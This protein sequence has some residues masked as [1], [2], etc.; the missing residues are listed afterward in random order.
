MMCA[1]LLAIWFPAFEFDY[2]TKGK[3]GTKAAIERLLEIIEEGK[4]EYV[5]VADIANF[6]RSAARELRISVKSLRRERAE[7]KIEFAQRRRRVFYPVNSIGQYR[8]AQVTRTCQTSTSAATD[9]RSTGMY[10]TRKADA[11]SAARLARQAMLR[12]RHGVTTSSA[13]N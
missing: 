8:Q 6:F 4:Y 12:R 2:L 13:K 9:P 7:G 10:S 5:V 1:D 11:A 3:G